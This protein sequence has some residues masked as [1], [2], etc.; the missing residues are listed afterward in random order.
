[1]LHQYVVDR[2]LGIQ[3]YADVR[4]FIVSNSIDKINLNLCP[5]LQ[6]YNND[7]LYIYI[8]ICLKCF[9]YLICII[10]LYASTTI[11]QLRFALRII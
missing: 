8:Y 7:A 4:H 3:R 6:S 2:Y 10:T 5:K 11:F 9:T 1:V